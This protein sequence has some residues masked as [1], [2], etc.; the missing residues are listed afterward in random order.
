[1][2]REKKP[3]KQ[4]IVSKILINRTTAETLLYEEKKVIL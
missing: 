2:G 4:S 1:M 3:K